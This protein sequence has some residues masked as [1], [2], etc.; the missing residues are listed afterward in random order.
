MFSKD[1]AIVA[2]DLLQEFG[3]DGYL[4][5]VTR[6][7]YNPGQGQR[8]KTEKRI[9]VKYVQE[10]YRYFDKETGLVDT[11]TYKITLYTPEKI[12]A[13]WKFEGSTLFPGT[14][15][16]IQARMITTQNTIVVY[17]LIVKG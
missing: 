2:M 13:T 11:G 17:E 12:D 9:H 8:D 5:Q 6:S 16:V 4:I 14:K 1:M 10:D 15:E 7:H 3:D